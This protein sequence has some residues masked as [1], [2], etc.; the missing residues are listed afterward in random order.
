MT[1]SGAL[2]GLLVADFSRVLAG[3]YATMLLA[4]LGA[5]VVKVERPGTG[6]DTRT[7]G[8]PYGEDGQATY[9]MAVNRNK[10]SVVLDLAAPEGRGLALELVRRADV[11]IENFSPGV[12]ERLGLGWDVVRAENPRAVYCS[13]TGFGHGHGRL[14]GYDLLVQA[15]GGLMSVTGDGTPTKVGV[16]LVDVITGLHAAFGTLAALRHRDATGVGQR[17]D[18]DLMTTSLAVLTNQSS[19]YVSAG[20]VPTP[21]GNRH[22]SIAPYDTFDS[23]D[24][25]IALACG[26]DKQFRALCSVLGLSALVDDE[27]F[28]TNPARVVHADELDALLSE[29]F[30]EEGADHWHR[31]LT[32]AGVPCG[33]VNDIAE[34]FAFAAS[35][36]LDTTAEVP[37]PDGTTLR[38][39]VD[40]VQMSAT[41]PTYRSAPPSLGADTDA[42]VAWLRSPRGTVLP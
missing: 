23:A 28:A 13:I 29:R 12:M 21:M 31:V 5:D 25:Q 4:D 7:W 37:A 24:R 10:R 33:P 14:P 32:E 27:R 2:D 16:A 26:N 11:V 41:P 18:V 22:P 36:G 3:P 19:A 38:Q 42:V 30:A 15:V 6:D 1:A 9:F 40:P 35:L 17:V 20:V 39:V 34:A 8:P